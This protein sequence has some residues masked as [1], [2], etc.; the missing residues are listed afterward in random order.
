VG[1]DRR[2]AV[3]GQERAQLAHPVVSGDQGDPPVGPV[4]GVPVLDPGRVNNVHRPGHRGP[5]RAGGLLGC[6]IEHRV[7]DRDPHVA[8]QAAGSFGDDPGPDQ[9][10]VSGLQRG[11][12]LRQGS[13]QVLGQVQAVAGRDPGQA[14]GQGDLVDDELHQLPRLALAAAGGMLG[15]FPGVGGPAAGGQF[16][17]LG[18]LTRLGPGLDLLPGPDPVDQLLVAAG[19]RFPHVQGASQARPGRIGKVPEPARVHLRVALPG[20]PPLDGLGAG[21]RIEHVFAYNA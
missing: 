19:A 9:V 12:H 5:H 16:G 18:Q 4:G 20:G 17:D 15:A 13:G 11:E 6:S 2:G 3:G 21:R 8:V 14:P 1:H 10:D 7:G